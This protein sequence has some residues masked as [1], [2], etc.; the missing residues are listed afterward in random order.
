MSE[1]SGGVA[2]PSH[3]TLAS[4]ASKRLACARAAVARSTPSLRTRSRGR[5]AVALC[6]HAVTARLVASD[7]TKTATMR[8]VGRSLSTRCTHSRAA[9]AEAGSKWQVP[10]RNTSTAP[11]RTLASRLGV[12]G[13]RT[14]AARRNCKIQW[15]MHRSCALRR[16]DTCTCACT[17]QAWHSDQPAL[18]HMPRAA[19]RTRQASRQE[20]EHR[21]PGRCV[22]G[23]RQRSGGG[24]RKSGCRA[25]ACESSSQ[26]LWSARAVSAKDR[27]SATT[28]RHSCYRPQAYGDT[29]VTHPCRG[30]DLA[31]MPPRAWAGL[32]RGRPG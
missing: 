21:Q 22:L 8:P 29:S 27:N 20:P 24:T 2:A 14:A 4:A 23:C 13:T 26:H 6:A 10:Q 31:P 25:D 11:Q 19:H 1:G 28:R 12:G 16:S 17:A 3:A 7:S 32:A 9:V 18:H 30:G 5:P 15:H